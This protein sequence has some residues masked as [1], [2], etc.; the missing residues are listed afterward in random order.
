MLEKA[1]GRLCRI[2]EEIRAAERG[3]LEGMS[4]I[5]SVFNRIPILYSIC[6]IYK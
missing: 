6:Y 4:G 3:V 2:S 5:G 1:S